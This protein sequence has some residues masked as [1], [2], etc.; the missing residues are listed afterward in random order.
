MTVKTGKSYYMTLLHT[1]LPFHFS[2]K[3]EEINSTLYIT[4]TSLKH[5]DLDLEGIECNCQMQS[6]LVIKGIV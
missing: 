1:F 3:G 5:D 2:I 6:V 4:R